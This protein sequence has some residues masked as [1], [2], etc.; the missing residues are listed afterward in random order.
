[1]TLADLAARLGCR[2]DG[3]GSIEV[4]R[5]AGIDDAGPGDVTFVANSKYVSRLPLTR[6]SAVILEDSVAGAP[7][8]TLRTRQPYLAMAEAVAILTPP[9]R[10]SPGISGL[11]TPDMTAATSRPGRTPP[12]TVSSS[13]RSVVPIATSATPACCVSPLTVQ[14]MVPGESSVPTDRNQWAPWASTPGMFANVSTLLANVG[15]AT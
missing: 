9:D 2:L 7:C 5:V 1:V 13:S 4:T 10:P 11:A 15:G 14:T 8:A 12:P 3:D 6:A